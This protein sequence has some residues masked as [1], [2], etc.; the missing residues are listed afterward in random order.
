MSLNVIL[1][2]N[3]AF[4]VTLEIASIWFLEAISG[5]TPP[6]FS[7]IGICVS[8]IFVVIW[9]T[10]LAGTIISPVINLVSTGILNLARFMTGK[11]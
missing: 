10:G 11:G 8:I 4:F 9:I 1:A 5:T 6:Y 3:S 7:C 2:S